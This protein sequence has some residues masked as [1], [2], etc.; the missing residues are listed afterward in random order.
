MRR[1]A[2]INRSITTTLNGEKLVARVSGEQEYDGDG[3][4]WSWS[5]EG[6]L[7]DLDLDEVEETNEELYEEAREAAIEEAFESAAYEADLADTYR[8]LGW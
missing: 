7:G 5:V 3:Y 6:T 8:S 2:K 1:N 4:S